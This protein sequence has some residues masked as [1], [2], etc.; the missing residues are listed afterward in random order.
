M[1][2]TPPIDL[3]ERALVSRFLAERSDAAFAALYTRCAPRVYGLIVR[4]LGARGATADDA[5][6]DTWMRAIAGL[7][8]FAWRS[9]LSTWI[10]GIAVNRCREARRANAR[11]AVPDT[12]QVLPLVEPPA[13]APFD[14]ASRIDLERAVAGLAPGYREVLVLHDVQG[15][16]H[17]EIA[18]LLGIEPGTSKSQL[19]RARRAMREALLGGETPHSPVRTQQKESTS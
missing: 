7:P 13:P 4:L 8:A 15:F 3:E 1:T 9:S 14:R 17:E 19:S 6:Q 2:D 12:A 11:D 5:F 16:T 18:T 10:C